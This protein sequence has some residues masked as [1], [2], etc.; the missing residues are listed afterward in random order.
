MYR[1]WSGFVSGSESPALVATDLDGT[2]LRDDKTVSTFT[3]DVLRKVA[4]AGIPVVPVTARQPYGLFPIAQAIGV[5]GPAIC[6]NGAV[7]V[8]IASGEV[9]LSRAIP[10]NVVRQLIQAVR[11][12]D[13]RV[14]FAAIGPQGEWFRAEEA[15]AAAS[16][17]TDHHRTRAEMEIVD[18][19]GLVADCSKVVLRCP[20]EAA[21]ATLERL[22]A[23]LGRCHATTSGAPFVEIMAEGVSKSSALAALCEQRGVPAKRVWAFG[24]AANDVDMLSWAGRAFAVAGACDEVRAI[25]DEIIGSNDNDAVARQLAVLIS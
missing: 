21:E 20:G 7:V 9:L 3:R 8:D 10:A 22:R 24:D 14:L 2:L 4:A 13:P 25:A 6:A 15:Y 23:V 12:E 19:D 17:F 16:K 11:R 18:E 5:E 1:T